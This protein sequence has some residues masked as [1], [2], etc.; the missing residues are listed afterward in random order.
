MTQR[1]E[2]SEDVYKLLLGSLP[3]GSTVVVEVSWAQT[4]RADASAPGAL[5]LVL[6][7]A[8]LHRYSSSLTALGSRLG[9]SGTD[10]AAAVDATVA[11]IAGCGGEEGPDH[12]SLRASLG[13]AAAT[14][15]RGVGSPSHQ[16]YLSVVAP[17]S[18]QGI[19]AATVIVPKSQVGRRGAGADCARCPWTV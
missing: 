4:L 9:G 13:F 12:R 6:P 2:S 14:P 1:S 7:A 5:R 8:L 17:A 11:T 10:V 19:T 15:I 16:P 18:P 3:A